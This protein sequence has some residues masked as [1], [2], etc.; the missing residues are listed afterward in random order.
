VLA[1]WAA[2]AVCSEV[3]QE[4][5]AE[6]Y[7]KENTDCHGLVL[8]NGLQSIKAVVCGGTVIELL[9]VEEETLVAHTVAVKGPLDVADEVNHT[10]G[11]ARS[12]VL[13]VSHLVCVAVV[14]VVIVSWVVNCKAGQTT[15]IKG[16]KDTII[17]V[18]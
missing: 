11:D 1:A 15:W 13:E 3:C 2:E 9:E 10:L 4:C 17:W 8:E 6:W 14:E 7:Q 5:N 18:S 12:H 16:L